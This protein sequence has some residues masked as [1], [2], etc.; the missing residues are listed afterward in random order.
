VPEKSAA[1]VVLKNKLLDSIYS[2]YIV[3]PFKNL[4]VEICGDEMPCLQVKRFTVRI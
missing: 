4:G 2:I 1:Y 3:M